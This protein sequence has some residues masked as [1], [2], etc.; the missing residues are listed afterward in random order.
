MQ[1][2]PYTPGETAREIPGRERQLT[3]I[4]GLLARVA[5]EG[6]LAGRIRVDVGPRGVGKTS[7]LRRAQRAATELGLTTVFVTA[8]N[9]TLTAVIADEVEQLLRSRG[10]GDVLA[11]ISNPTKLAKR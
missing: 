3:E 10:H 9:G 6:R 11:G 7:L 5:L 4:S 8:G 1:P 2:S